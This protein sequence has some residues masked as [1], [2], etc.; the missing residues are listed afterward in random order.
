MFKLWSELNPKAHK[1]LKPDF[2]LRSWTSLKTGEK[3]T[4]WKH[5]EDHF[6]N[7]DIKQKYDP[8]YNRN[9]QYY[10]F[11]GS[12]D[13]IREKKKRISFTIMR[14]N[15]AYKANNYVPSFLE[16]KTF[17]AACHDFYNLF[18]EGTENVV[19][20]LLSIFTDTILIE[21]ENKQIRRI[22]DETDPQYEERLE[23]WRWESFENFA[24]H[25]NEV[26]N[27][28]CL[29]IQI[30][31]LGFVPKQEQKIEEEIYKPVL[32]KLSNPKWK[33][34]NRD[35]SDAFEDYRKKDYS[36]CVTHT[37]STIQAF[38]QILVN[39]K[40]GQ[41]DISKLISEARKSKL[42]PDDDFSI[43]FFD[44]LESYMARTRQEKGDPHPKKEYA[45]DK[46]ARLVLNLTMVFFE[47]SL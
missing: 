13:E 46:N 43:I 42:I 14:I 34:V 8:E 19:L 28:F 45:T 23:A 3:Y 32:T 29:N 17:N 36:G 12:E 37:I 33:E 6:F 15:E 4:I 31:R 21:R 18:S 47:H 22:E 25:I 7:K 38:L 16:H 11:S 40:T 35:L 24:T 1:E 26:F 41:G 2:G 30:T 9:I 20:E 44:Q 39:G 27:Q 10:E 5:L